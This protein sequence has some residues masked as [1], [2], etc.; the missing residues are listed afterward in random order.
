MIIECVRNEGFENQLTESS[1]YQVKEL[2]EN[3]Y[4]IENDEQQRRW[5]GRQLFTIKLDN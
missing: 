1:A 2:G 3:S 4:L 5:Y